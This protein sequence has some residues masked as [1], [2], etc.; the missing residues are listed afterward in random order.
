M[1]AHLIEFASNCSRRG[2]LFI[3]VAFLH[4]QL[5]AH[6]GRGQARVE[7]V[8]FELGIRLTLSIDNGSDICQ[9]I[10]QVLF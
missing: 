10:G 3:G 7:S 2:Q 9:Q 1:V 8:R 6:L 5:T 4:N